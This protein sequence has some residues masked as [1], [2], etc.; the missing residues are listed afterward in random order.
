MA[1]AAEQPRIRK[2]QRRRKIF[3]DIDRSNSEE[4]R[5]ASE[6]PN[7][8]VGLEDN[9]EWPTIDE[10]DD[11][12]FSVVNPTSYTSIQEFCQSPLEY[13]DLS[14]GCNCSGEHVCLQLH[15]KELVTTTSNPFSSSNF[16]S[17]RSD[18]D[19]CLQ[20][21]SEEVVGCSCEWRNVCDNV[22]YATPRMNIVCTTCPQIQISS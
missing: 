14:Q 8:Y 18:L 4:A 3:A 13:T 1:N 9:S 22:I 21:N 2:N 7:Y 19:W 16:L 6:P 12:L 15:R 11:F 5:E 17:A 10:G 20:N